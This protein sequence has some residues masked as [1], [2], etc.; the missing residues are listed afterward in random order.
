MLTYKVKSPSGV[1]C[2]YTKIGKKAS[3]LIDNFDTSANWFEKQGWEV[4]KDGKNP[5]EATTQ[6]QK[7]YCGVC[8]QEMQF[9]QGMSKTGKPWKGW[10]CQTKG[11]EP[12][13]E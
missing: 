5:V 1:V 3:E 12:I 13:W 2:E 9:K 6:S 10:F 8:G 4:V 11:H 7:R